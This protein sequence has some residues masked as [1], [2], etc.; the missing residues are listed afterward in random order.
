MIKSENNLDKYFFI[1]KNGRWDGFISVD[2]LKNIPVKK[3]DIKIVSEFNQSIN[4]FPSIV[5]NTP[6]WQII[7]KIEK[8]NG[9]IIL[10]INPYGIP[11]GLLDRKNIGF[12][13]LKKLGFNIS[14][15]ILNKIKSKSNYPL[16]IELPKIIKLMKS[17]GDI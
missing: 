4:T 16:G 8:T 15:E 2:A 17:K 3:W 6:L 9:G 7:E 5:E 13:V 1:T 11:K 10:I 14:N 12:F